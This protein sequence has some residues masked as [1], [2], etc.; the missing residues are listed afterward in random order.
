MLHGNMSLYGGGGAAVGVALHLMRA[1]L[2][3]MM[4]RSSLHPPAFVAPFA[5]APLVSP[6]AS[7]A[8][9]C[10]P[11]STKVSPHTLCSMLRSAGGAPVLGRLLPACAAYHAQPAARLSGVAAR[12]AGPAARREAR[13]RTHL[14]ATQPAPYHGRRGG[15][16]GW[17]RRRGRRGWQ[18]CLSIRLRFWR[19]Q[20]HRQQQE[21]PT[22][23]PQ[24]RLRWLVWAGAA[25]PAQQWQRQHLQPPQQPEQRQRGRVGWPLHITAHPQPDS[26]AQA[27]AAQRQATPRRLA[28]GSL[29][30]EGW[31]RVWLWEGRVRLWYPTS[32]G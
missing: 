22:E 1:A 20:W 26:A 6:P 29:W 14:C 31:A 28:G 8:A 10:C 25:P 32:V 18:P 15:G 24:R 30:L 2:K 16:P 11:A 19:R 9:S 23:P 17:C 27:A 7:T 4:H 13:P 21:Q 3:C 12:T 5:L